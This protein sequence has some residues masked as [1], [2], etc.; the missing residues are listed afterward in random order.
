[1]SAEPSRNL[2]RLLFGIRRL[3][4]TRTTRGEEMHIV[5]SHGRTNEANIQRRSLLRVEHLLHNVCSQKRTDDQKGNVSET[6]TSAPVQ[7]IEELAVVVRPSEAT[8]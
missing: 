6:G 8:H 2:G 5:V 3:G 1:M 7:I 4:P